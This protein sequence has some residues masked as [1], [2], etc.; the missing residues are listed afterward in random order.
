MELVMNIGLV[1]LPAE[2]ADCV[3]E[4]VNGFAEVPKPLDSPTAPVTNRSPAVVDRSK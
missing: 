4:T 2:P 1:S 3:I